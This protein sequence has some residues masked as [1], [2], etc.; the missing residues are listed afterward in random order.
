MY[1]LK[2]PSERMPL[3]RTTYRPAA[4][5]PVGFSALL[6]DWW[7]FRGRPVCAKPDDFVTKRI[8]DGVLLFHDA[9]QAEDSHNQRVLGFKPKAFN[10][11]PERPKFRCKSKIRMI[12]D[13]RGIAAR[14]TGLRWS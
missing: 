3:A 4:N 6:L 9:L 13:T 1:S 12:G 2:A 7:S 8:L 5:Q 10:A 11:G 14:G